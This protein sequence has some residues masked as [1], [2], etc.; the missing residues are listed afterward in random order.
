VAS[1]AKSA[2]SPASAP[3]HCERSEAI[4][5]L[6]SHL[7]LPRRFAPRNDGEVMLAKASSFVHGKRRPDRDPRL[8]T[9]DSRPVNALPLEP[10]ARPDAPEDARRGPAQYTISVGL[11]PDGAARREPDGRS[12]AAAGYPL[13]PQAR[14]DVLEDARRGPGRRARRTR[15]YV[16]PAGRAS[17]SRITGRMVRALKPRNFPSCLFSDPASAASAPATS[18]TAPA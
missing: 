7:R 4:S 12:R 17:A 13:E 11:I 8:V 9:R 10:Q 16:K 3:R 6:V 14:P 1:R 15:T 5:L 2:P 18:A